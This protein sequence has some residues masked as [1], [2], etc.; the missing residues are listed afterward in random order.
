MRFRILADDRKEVKAKLEELAG[1]RA[2]YTRMPR[3]AFI[4]RGIDVEKNGEVTTE[5]DADMDLVRELIGSGLISEAIVEEGTTDP[6]LCDGANSESGGQDTEQ[7]WT[8]LENDD[9]PSGLNECMEETGQGADAP[10]TVKPSVSFPLEAHRPESVINLVNTIFSK[11]GLISKSTGGT[12]SA[13]EKLVQELQEGHYIQT[14][15][16]IRKVD[17]EGGLTGVSFADGKV[18]FD[19]FPETDDPDTLKAWMAFAA[20]VNSA[21]IKQKHVRAKLTDEPNEKFAFR[22]WLTRLGMNGQELKTERGILYRNLSGHTAFRTEEDARK[23]KERQAA[24]RQELRER[25][26]GN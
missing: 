26:E 8:S 20:A 9:A 1:E 18:T 11:G 6:A 21:C 12:F 3:C 4:L 19:G 13:S 10:Q 23:W 25:E 15:D 24:K 17:G 7:E 2:V 5:E 16:V 14:E 22:T